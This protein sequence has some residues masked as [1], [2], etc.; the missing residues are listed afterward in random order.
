MEHNEL[1]RHKP[2]DLRCDGGQHIADSDGNITYIPGD[3]DCTAC[4]GCEYDYPCPTIT[5]QQVV[6]ND[7]Q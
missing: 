1:L 5:A 7:T 2:C 3:K 6:N 4:M